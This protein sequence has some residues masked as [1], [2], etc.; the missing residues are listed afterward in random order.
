MA[1]MSNLH[2]FMFCLFNSNL[3]NSLLHVFL[4]NIVGKL[5]KLDG[6]LEKRGVRDI[7]TPKLSTGAT[8]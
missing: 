5:G 1:K 3:I 7:D 2:K 4:T 6:A 8:E